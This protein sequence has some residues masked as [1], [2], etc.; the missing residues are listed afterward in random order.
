MSTFNPLARQTIQGVWVQDQ[1]QLLDR[2]YGTAGVRWDDTSKA[3][4]A[5]TYRVTGL[6]RIDETGTGLHGSIG[7]GFRQPSL[8]ENLFAF[9][10][11]NLRPERSKGW[12]CGL[13]QQ[14]WDN[15]I[16]VDATYFRNDFRDLIVFNPLIPPFGQLDNIS[17][18]RSSGVELSL[19]LQITPTLSANAAYTFDDTLSLDP[20]TPFFGEDLVRRPRNKVSLTVTQLLA[21]DTASVTLQMLYVGTRLDLGPLD[22]LTFDNTLLTLDQYTLLN[23]AAN[24]T[25]SDCCELIFRLDNITNTEYEEVNGFGAPGFGMYGGVNLFW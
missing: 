4:P 6:Y 18:A 25:P 1:F 17:A 12:D 21:G 5:Q 16:A 20:R 7:T 15:A 23:L 2:L 13:R 19:L 24:W 8:A 10:N 11:P 3:G 9:G 22:P 14:I